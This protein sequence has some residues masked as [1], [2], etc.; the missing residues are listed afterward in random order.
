MLELSNDTLTVT[1][2]GIAARVGEAITKLQMN[3]TENAIV[4]T[5]CAVDATARKRFGDIGNRRRFTGFLAE[6]EDFLVYGALSFTTHLYVKGKLSFDKLGTLPELI[7]TNLRNPLLHEAETGDNVMLLLR[8]REISFG[9]KDQKFV[10][11]QQLVLAMLLLVIGAKENEKMN[12]DRPWM[13]TVNGNDLSLN[14]LWGQMDIIK[15][16][17]G[18]EERP[19]ELVA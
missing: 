12:F 9:F 8:E 17:V 4:Q 18:F 7:Y 1:M 19:P 3:D 16:Q 6:N 5:A 10:V 14:H 2:K 11:S 13:L 15:R